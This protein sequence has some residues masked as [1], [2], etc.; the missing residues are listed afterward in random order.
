MLSLKY[1]YKKDRHFNTY[2]KDI[3]VFMPFVL[4]QRQLLMEVKGSFIRS[5]PP[6]QKWGIKTRLAEVSCM[7]SVCLIW[8]R[9]NP[10]LSCRGMQKSLWNPGHGR[11]KS[12]KQVIFKCCSNFWAPFSAAIPLT[13]CYIKK[14]KWLDNTEIQLFYHTHISL[15]KTAETKSHKTF[16]LNC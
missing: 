15:F 8:L 7:L 5:P 11:Q 1:K 3:F 10:S 4:W 12:G 16:T 13:D 2:I 9:K 14:T 6:L